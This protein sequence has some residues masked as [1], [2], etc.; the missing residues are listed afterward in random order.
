M[1]G[2]TITAVNERVFR[3]STKAR[4]LEQLA[5]RLQTA[6]CCEQIIVDQSLW[7][8][9]SEA[10]ARDIANRW[11]AQLLAVRSSSGSEDGVDSSNAGAFLSLVNVNPEIAE[12]SSAIDRVFGSYGAGQDEQEVLVQPMVEDVIISGV[13]MTRDLDTGAPYYVINY[14]DFSGR[15]DTVTSG[16][17]SKMTM[18][19]RANPEAL[20]SPRM[21][22]LVEMA[23]ELESVT[24]VHTLDIEFCACADLSVY[25]LQVRPVPASRSWLEIPDATVAGALDN[26]RKRLKSIL[27]PM[28]GIA[29]DTTI[30]GEMPDWNPAEMIGST[31]RPLALSLY[32][33]LITDRTWSAARAAMGYRDVPHP[34]MLN[35]NG[36]PFIDVRLS[37]NSFLP[38]TLNPNL[39]RRLVNHQIALLTK[40]KEWHDKVEFKVAT[41]C[42]DF[43]FAER[44]RELSSAGFSNDDIEE[45]RSSLLDITRAGLVGGRDALIREL[46]DT[47]P[48]LEDLLPPGTAG[49]L[50]LIR[51]QLRKTIQHGSFP[52]AK[53]ARHGFVGV[54]LLNSLVERDVLSQDEASRFM[55][56]INT[57][58]TRLIHDMQ[59]LARDQMPQDAFLKEYG[60]LRPGTYDITSWR[61]DERPELYLS[62]GAGHVL[63]KKISE[64][65]FA[66]SGE[67]KQRI[68]RLA[69]DTG[70]DVD[71]D[72]LMQY[73]ATAIFA[74]EQAK[75]TYSRGVSDILSLLT[76]WG[77]KNAFSRDDLTYLN[78]HDLNSVEDLASHLRR[79]QVTARDAH[80]L[81]RMVRLHYLITEEADVDVVFPARGQPTFITNKSVTAPIKHLHANEGG[82]LDGKI[83]MIESA[84]PG[85]DWIFSHNIAGLITQFG[86]ANSH[87]AIRCAEFGLPAAI[88]C[89]ERTFGELLSANVV[90]LNCATRKLSRH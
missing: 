52:F 78:I 73:I 11:P 87:M 83:I 58:A 49:E 72:G 90:E 6:R 28:D 65:Q 32:E 74:R 61:Y 25:V 37:F 55:Y 39:A 24:G 76:Q 86:G 80:H 40:N 67:Q 38:K 8:H 69:R 60:H 68:D 5:G 85:F 62:H 56:G 77:D 43:S 46:G 17:I 48:L 31:P 47:E 63:S 20:H 21:R 19:H 30:L 79:Q 3:F 42:L 7:R 84:D 22:K 9:N 14:D 70:F 4:N 45:L 34:L 64:D 82:N 29:G 66:L 36:R 50:S 54:L 81:T 51:T 2:N 35:F 13:I 57:I 15:T 88:G 1:P 89:G 18:V 75:F 33:Y 53:L 26:V 59:D 27:G 71:N 12:I 23:Q 16:G 10:I 44:A 41:T